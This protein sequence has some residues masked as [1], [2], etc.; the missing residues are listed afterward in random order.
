[1]RIVASS[2][3]SPRAP[4]ADSSLPR[5]QFGTMAQMDRRWQATTVKKRGG[6]DGFNPFGAHR[7][8]IHR[9]TAWPVNE[10]PA[11]MCRR[12]GSRRKEDQPAVIS[13][14]GYRRKLANVMASAQSRG[15]Q[16]Y[17]E[18]SKFGAPLR[19]KPRTLMSLRSLCNPNSSGS[20][21]RTPRPNLSP[22]AERRRILCCKQIVRRLEDRRAR[23]SLLVAEVWSGAYPFQII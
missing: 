11:M 6:G 1:M 15:S 13:L 12:A 8:G 18:W 10:R 9:A 5:T 22:I 2:V 23:V 17:S 14:C 21:P 19:I 4:F 20:P 16:F 7:V 3:P